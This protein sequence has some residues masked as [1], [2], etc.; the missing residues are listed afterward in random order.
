M[1]SSYGPGKNHTKGIKFDFILA[2]GVRV[3][4]HKAEEPK[5]KKRSKKK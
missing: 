5:K 4:P 3:V 1:I 2:E